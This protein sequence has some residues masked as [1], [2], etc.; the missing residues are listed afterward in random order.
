M[1]L[2]SSP[3]AASA[4]AGSRPRARQATAQLRVSGSL[5]GAALGNRDLAMQRIELAQRC[6]ASVRAAAG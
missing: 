5:R 4:S 6:L 1:A 3:C 2:R